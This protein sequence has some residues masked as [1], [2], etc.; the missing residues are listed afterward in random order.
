MGNECIEYARFRD[1]YK[2][3]SHILLSLNK[4]LGGIF[5]WFGASDEKISRSLYQKRTRLP[6]N[7]RTVFN[8]LK[9]D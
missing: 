8:N 1:E 9:I 7:T 2:R 4:R 5:S 6:I 3:R